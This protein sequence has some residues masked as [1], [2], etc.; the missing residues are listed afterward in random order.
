MARCFSGPPQRP[1]I[2]SSDIGFWFF[3]L[4]MLWVPPPLSAQLEKAKAANRTPSEA[5]VDLRMVFTDVV[6]DLGL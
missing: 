3:G 4:P 6:F 1:G 5:M 2:F